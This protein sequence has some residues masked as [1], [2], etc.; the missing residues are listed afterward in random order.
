MAMLSAD[1][2]TQVAAAVAR[3]E[4]R[5]SG[6]WVV[7]VVPRCARYGEERL[8]VAAAW[9]VG[10]CFLAYHWLATIPGYWFILGQ[11]PLTLLLYTLMR[12]PW[13]VRRLVRQQR[14][15]TAVQARAH[16]VFS[17]QG[18]YKTRDR[19]GLLILIAEAEHQ[20]V[21]LADQGIDATV[22]AAGW[23]KYVQAIVAGIRVK[24]LGHTLVQVIDD[25]GVL[26]AAHHPRRSDDINELP[27][28]VVDL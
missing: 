7:A 23:T 18:I 17:Q 19:T 4:A 3:A 22:G 28:A 14:M 13:V 12:A 9:S 2:K 5:S 21:I 25:L 26:V 1:D 24:R 11:L 27:D 6:E 10:L 16:Q 8:M 20:V 15:Q